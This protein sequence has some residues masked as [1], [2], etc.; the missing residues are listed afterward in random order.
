MTF[1][2]EWDDMVDALERQY[3]TPDGEACPCPVLDEYV[4]FQDKS[5]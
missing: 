3:A 2:A 5:A 4:Q 1:P